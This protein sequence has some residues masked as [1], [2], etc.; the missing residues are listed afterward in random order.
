MLI[1]INISA[2][3]PQLSLCVRVRDQFSGIF[4]LFFLILKVL[5]SSCA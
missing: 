2:F 4:I 3:P 5:F 1:F